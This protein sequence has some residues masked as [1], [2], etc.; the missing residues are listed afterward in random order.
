MLD[1]EGQGVRNSLR[2][3]TTYRF[4]IVTSIL[5]VTIGLAISSTS[6]QSQS[7]SFYVDAAAGNDSNSGS[8]QT[9]A[10]R[11]VAKVNVLAFA[12][13]DTIYFK[14]GGLW[15]ETLEPG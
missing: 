3:K 11:T 15:R 9:S 12:P 2:H 5:V 7:R 6:A 8:S 1:F 10:W 13:G 14:R 4:R